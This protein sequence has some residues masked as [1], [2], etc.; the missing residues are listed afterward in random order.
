MYKKMKLLSTVL[1]GEMEVGKYI[2]GISKRIT[3]KWGDSAPYHKNLKKKMRMVTQRV[4][5]MRKCMKDNYT[6]VRMRSK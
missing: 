4:S 3:F 6:L 2:K 5:K 1:L